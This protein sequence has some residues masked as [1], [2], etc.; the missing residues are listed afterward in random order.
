MGAGRSELARILFGLDPFEHGEIGIGIADRE[1]QPC[2]CMDRGMAFLTEDRRGEGLMM[3]ASIDDNIALPSLSSFASGFA[4]MIERPGSAT[5]SA[6]SA[7]PSRSAPATSSA[8]SSGTSPAATSRRSS[9]A[10]AP[11]RA[12]RLHPRRADAGYRC[13]REVRGLQDH[14]PPCRGRCRHPLHLLRD[15]GADRH[16]R[17][18]HGHGAWRDSRRVRARQVRPRGDPERRHVGRHKGSWP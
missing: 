4:R 5:R 11:A 12:P 17:P 18:H 1:A 13:R 8:P 14:Q 2:A 9:S 3:E 7:Q 6:R 15:R 16:V 10:M